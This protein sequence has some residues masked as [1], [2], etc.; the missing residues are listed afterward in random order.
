[1]EFWYN[2]EVNKR[3]YVC[4]VSAV[5]M[6]TSHSNGNFSVLFRTNNLKK[7]NSVTNSNYPSENSIYP[8][9]ESL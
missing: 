7:E 5:I 1:M 3:F 8:R 6:D 2:L 9:R 4:G